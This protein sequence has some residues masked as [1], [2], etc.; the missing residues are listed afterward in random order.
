M[1]L[2]FSHSWDLS[3]DEAIRLQREMSKK[4]VSVGSPSIRYVAGIDVSTS[5]DDEEGYAAVVVM[6]YP[7]LE[8]VEV[9]TANLKIPMVYIPGLL[10][11]RESPI[12]VKAL[13]KL[14][15]EPDIFMV[16]GQGIAHPRRFGIAA[17]L[18][19]L[20]DK[21]SIGVAKTRLVGSYKEPGENKGDYSLLMDNG[22]VIGAV[23]RTRKGVK[24]VFVS[25]GHRCNLDFAIRFTLSCCTKYRLPEPTRQAHI[26]VNKY[27]RKMQEGS[28]QTSLFDLS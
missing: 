9:A 14:K 10:S 19:V 17:H 13:E 21:P 5:K 28:S 26:A 7:E 1:K 25:V 23:L 4:V 6:K 11:F 12:I 3:P 24:P 27:R 20:F 15:T 16:D 2:K 18:G 22:E 8:V